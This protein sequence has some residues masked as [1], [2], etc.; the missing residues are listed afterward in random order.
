MQAEAAPWSGAA[1]V[2]LMRS[3]PMMLGTTSMDH[4]L[5]WHALCR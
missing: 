3:R 1:Y 4:A 2:Q 5:T